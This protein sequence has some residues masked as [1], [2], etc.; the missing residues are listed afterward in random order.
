M[1]VRT[2]YLA[3]LLSLFLHCQPA[4]ADDAAADTSSPDTLSS[5]PPIILLTQPLQ[6]DQG[7][8]E[9]MQA[10]VFGRLVL[11]NG[12]LRV[13]PAEGEGEP[14]TIV[15]PGGYQVR[16]QG[17]RIDILNESQEDVA[18]VGDL[19]SMDG[20]EVSSYQGEN[21][22]RCPGKYWITGNEVRRQGE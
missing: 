20:G 22:G 3:A 1:I 10:L 11:E 18:S 14:Y 6:E 19:I 21:A 16:Q 12:C 7:P 4:P 5:G 2:L 13:Q 15:W 8:R 17:D 9:V